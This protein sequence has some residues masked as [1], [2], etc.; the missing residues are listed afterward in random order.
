MAV[1]D[2]QRMEELMRELEGQTV[3]IVWSRQCGIPERFRLLQYRSEIGFV[4]L[5]EESRYAEYESC[6]HGGFWVEIEAIA[7]IRPVALA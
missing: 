7:A 5:C 6:L 3:E 4:K 2:P 1:D